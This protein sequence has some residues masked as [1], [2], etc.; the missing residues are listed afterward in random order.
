[1]NGRLYLSAGYDVVTIT[2][3]GSNIDGGQLISFG[4]DAPAMPKSWDAT[5][6]D[7]LEPFDQAKCERV[8]AMAEDWP[9]GASPSASCASC[10]CACD[11]TAAGNCDTCWS[12]QTCAVQNCAFSAP[13]EDM[14]ACMSFFCV[15]KLLPPYRFERSVAVAP[16]AI[17]CESQCGF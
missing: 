3:L 14:H 8:V 16:C 10:L 5:V 6:A 4:L 7:E 2:T 15:T 11:A 1:V 17:Q 9:S 13:G 12:Q